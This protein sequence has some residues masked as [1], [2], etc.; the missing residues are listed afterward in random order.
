M[1]PCGLIRDCR[2]P[3]SAAGMITDEHRKGSA[4]RKKNRRRE[5]AG[6]FADAGFQMTRGCQSTFSI[7]HHSWLTG[8]RLQ[9][10]GL[11]GAAEKIRC[12]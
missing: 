11:A 1:T 4:C 2:F 9:I 6:L 12:C 7:F 10:D 3:S 8:T 5:P